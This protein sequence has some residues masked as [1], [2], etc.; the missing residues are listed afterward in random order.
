MCHEYYQQFKSTTQDC[1]YGL[2]LEPDIDI[3]H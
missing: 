2:E 3:L 1:F